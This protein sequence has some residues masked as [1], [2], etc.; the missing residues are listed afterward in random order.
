MNDP[1][2]GTRFTYTVFNK[3]SNLQGDTMRNKGNNLMLLDYNFEESQIKKMMPGASASEFAKKHCDNLTWKKRSKA[4][5]KHPYQ[6]ILDQLWTPRE[7]CDRC[8][9]SVASSNGKYGGLINGEKVNN[10]EEAISYRAAQLGLLESRHIDFR[11]EY[12][13]NGY[14]SIHSLPDGKDLCL[15]DAFSDSI[16]KPVMRKK[17]QL[18]VGSLEFIK[19]EKCIGL[20]VNIH[21]LERSITQVAGDIAE[22]RFLGLN[23]DAIDTLVFPTFTHKAGDDFLCYDLNTKSFSGKD[24]KATRFPDHFKSVYKRL[25]DKAPLDDPMSTRAEAMSRPEMAL[26]RLYTGQGHE[27]FSSAP[28][29]LLVRNPPGESPN[30][31]ASIQAQFKNFYT[32]KF[33]H[34]CGGKTVQEFEVKGAQIIFF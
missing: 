1:T 34:K 18:R 5:L 11:D 24:V 4:T 32:F 26:R 25:S 30:S 14:N 15:P 13:K 6:D 2:S 12:H 21:D 27:R 3:T 16:V 28:R 9:E 23:K 31:A 17:L 33:E 19:V 29:L 22:L 8:V 7:F 10:I 20:L